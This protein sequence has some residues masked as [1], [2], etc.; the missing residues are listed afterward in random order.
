MKT[1][2]E[3]ARAYDEALER[4]KKLTSDLTTL[5]AIREFIFPEL[6]ESK[7]ERI[8]K[9]LVYFI[10]GDK[11]YMEKDG[12]TYLTRKNSP[13]LDFFYE[14][15]EWLEKQKEQVTDESDKIAAAYQ[16]ARSD[17]RKQKEQKL[18]EWSEEDER[19]YK[20]V[21]GKID[22]EQSYNVS[23]VDMLNWLKSIRSNGSRARSRWKIFG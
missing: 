21:F 4:A 16:L 11:E 6:K 2:E 22:H 20:G 18:T 7:D 8:R 10:Q 13:R 17:E 15:L 12:G 3:K 19:I 5:Q 14:A 23:K 1:I 9:E